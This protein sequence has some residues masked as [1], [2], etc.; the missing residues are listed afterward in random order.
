MPKRTRTPKIP[1]DEERCVALVRGTDRR[2]PH[3]RARGY[4]AYCRAHGMTPEQRAE[5]SRIGHQAKR[6][7]AARRR[8]AAERA[9]LGLQAML[10]EELERQAAEIVARLLGILRAGSDADALRAADLVL[11]RVYGRPVQPVAST[12]PPSTAEEVR[13]MT[14]EE[15]RALLARALPALREPA[16]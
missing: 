1:P 11:S 6:E 12:T 9:K 13:A 14:P 2:C 4:G 16:G 10:A 7:Q 15:R 5:L 8:E 3:R